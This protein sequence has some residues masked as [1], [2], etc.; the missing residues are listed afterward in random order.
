MKLYASYHIRTDL[1][2]GWGIGLSLVLERETYVIYIYH[3]NNMEIFDVSWTLYKCY[4]NALCL[5]GCCLFI[6][7]SYDVYFRKLL[8]VF[9]IIM[10]SWIL[11]VGISCIF[12]ELTLLCVDMYILIHIFMTNKSVMTFNFFMSIKHIC[13]SLYARSFSVLSQHWTIADSGDLSFTIFSLDL[14][15]RR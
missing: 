1:G 13:V 15:Y 11:S 12:P 10:E 14:L 5:L 7:S 6:L 8:C 4:T 2:G 3:G 9:S